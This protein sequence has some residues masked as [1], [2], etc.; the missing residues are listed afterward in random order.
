MVSTTHIK[1]LRQKLGLKKTTATQQETLLAA[2]LFCYIKQED[3]Y[4][5]ILKNVQP[6]QAFCKS[7]ISARGIAH[8]AIL[9][10]NCQFDSDLYCRILEK[11]YLPFNS[12]FYN[13]YCRL[14]QNNAPPHKY[15][16]ANDMLK[17]WR[18]TH[19]NGL[20]SHQT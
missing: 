17:I 15:R 6:S 16:C 4:L 13:G 18:L 7:G 11:C 8:F 20:R 12:D 19:W 1:R 14:V 2:P 10:G 3:Q 9:P 5:P